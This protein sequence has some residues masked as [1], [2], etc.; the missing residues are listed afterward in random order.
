MAS[1][2]HCTFLGNLTRSP[3]MRVTPQGTAIAQFSLAINRKWRAKDG[4]AKEEVTF[5]DFEAWDKSAENISKYVAKGDPLFVTARAKV[6]VWEDKE[7][8]KNRS[9]VKFVVVDFQLLGSKRDRQEGG[10]QEQAPRS[11]APRESMP[12]DPDELIDP[13]F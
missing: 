13:P 9:K 1:Y 5:L 4:T 6:D 3:E 2:N 8:K 10:Q 12:G 7:T 11:S